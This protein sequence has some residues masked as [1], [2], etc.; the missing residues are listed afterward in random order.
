MALVD[1]LKHQPLERE[2][3]HTEVECTYDIVIDQNGE[4]CIQLDTYGSK[5]RKIP[6]KKSQSL[7]LSPNAISELKE[8]FKNNKM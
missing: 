6:G 4:K 8:I 1:K 7:R 3:T 2:S 5:A